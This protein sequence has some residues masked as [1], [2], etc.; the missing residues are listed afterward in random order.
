MPRA[1]FL[2]FL[3][4]VACQSPVFQSIPNSSQSPLDLQIQ[5][6]G[7][8]MNSQQLTDFLIQSAGGKKQKVPTNTW[9][10]L[11]QN[12]ERTPEL[13]IQD[14]TLTDTG[15]SIIG[16]DA[17]ASIQAD[18]AGK[19]VRLTLTGIFKDK[20][21]D[22]AQ[23]TFLFTLDPELTQQTFLLNAQKEPKSR[24]LLDRSI[25]L[26]TEAVSGNQIQ[27][28]FNTERL[29]ELYLKGL[30]LLSVEHG[31]YYTD[32][33]VRSGVPE[34]VDS[35][36]PQIEAVEVL[37]GEDGK[38]SHVWIKGQNL[39]VATKLSYSTI[40]SQF[41]FGYQTEVL[42]DGSSET[43]IH[44]PDLDTFDINVSHTLTYATPFGTAF[45]QFG[46]AQ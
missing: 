6:A 42:A 35:L 25:L 41:S 36:A 5:V 46:G 23:K 28:K 20:K 18:Y 19:E 16:A 22:L 21:K 27:V 17:P 45:T 12:V 10:S 3:G 26:Q 4:L 11:Q 13:L 43:T 15:Q 32:V 1:S 37:Q 39:M 7:Q 9:H 14:V 2:L 40:D 31:R 24:V 29:P 44:I 34:P 38:P 8:T 33:L 30:H